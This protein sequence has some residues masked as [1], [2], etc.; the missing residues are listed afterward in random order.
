MLEVHVV[1]AIL[2]SFVRDVCVVV[3]LSKRLV[4]YQRHLDTDRIYMDS[5]AS[6]RVFYNSRQ[7]DRVLLGSE[8]ECRL[9]LI[10]RQPIF[11]LLGGKR[12]RKWLC[13]HGQ[14]GTLHIHLTLRGC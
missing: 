9:L 6:L 7:G 10:F 12:G 8:T 1:T 4:S 14:A 13:Y 5:M 2:R 11:P 3:P